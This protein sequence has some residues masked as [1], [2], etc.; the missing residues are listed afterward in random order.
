MWLGLC[1]LVIHV[2]ACIVFVN[3]PIRLSNDLGMMTSSHQVPCLSPG[4]TLGRSYMIGW[5]IWNMSDWAWFIIYHT[6]LSLFGYIMEFFHGPADDHI[7]AKITYFTDQS[8]SFYET[9]RQDTVCLGSSTFL[10]MWI[11][12]GMLML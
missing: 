7:G 1:E 6:G 4:I 12:E 8:E 2:Y 5:W 11:R 9:I 10:S 3:N